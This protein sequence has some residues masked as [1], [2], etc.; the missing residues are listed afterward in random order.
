ME[1]IMKIG[2]RSSKLAMAYAQK[3]IDALQVND[4]EIVPIV[5]EGD[6][7]TNT[8]IQEI[9]GKGVFVSEIEKHLLE[10]TIDIAVHSFKDL[11]AEMDSE[12]DIIAVL[13]RNDPR[14]CYIGKLH[15][16]ARVGTGSPRRI[17]QLQK[18]F[19]V[20][21]DIRPIRGNIDTRLKKLDNNEYDA[22]IL[23]VAGL[24]ALQLQERI[25]KVFPLDKM[26]PCV[27]QG[28]IA[29]QSRKDF[30]DIDTISKI[31]HLPT[32]YSVMAEREVLKV[33]QGDCHTAVG[34]I[35]STV[36]DCIILQA[37]NYENDKQYTTIG[38]QEDY[39]K[40]GQE[41]GNNIK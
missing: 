3:V 24:E 10:K 15:P 38:K 26:L 14:D 23:A 22:I 19:N 9:G 11:P 20:E 4:T 27:G 37:I 1:F 28:V 8:S 16:Y 6:I 5:T 21:F 2:V 7:K 12:L 40:L 18:N 30:N 33:I 25:Q 13:E 41:V 31:N 17:A 35:S 34:V 36:G 29:V 32:Y 39:L